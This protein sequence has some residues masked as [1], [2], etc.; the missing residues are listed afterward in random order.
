MKFF[1]FII[2]FLFITSCSTPKS[3]YICGDHEC[4]NADEA[5]AYFEENLILEIRILDNK[6]INSY[7]LVQLNT[8]DNS[9]KEQ[10]TNI[11]NSQNKVKKLS[12]KEIKQKKNEL[13]ERKKI[14]KIKQKNIES[15]KK[16]LKKISVFDKKNKKLSKTKI[17]KKNIN[18][19]SSLNVKKKIYKNEICEVVEK[20]NIDE[21]AKYLLNKSNNKSFPDLTKK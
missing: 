1:K 6:N 11:F 21:I 15:N 9:D 5:K 10:K 16:E 2:V 4:I 14:A 18:K 12:K 20:C 3:V 17:V 7:D 8:K 13:I 19:T